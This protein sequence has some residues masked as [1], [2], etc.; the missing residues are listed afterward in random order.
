[1][2]NDDVIENVGEKETREEVA[3]NQEQVKTYSEEEVEAIKEQMKADNQK[4]WN[5]RWGM[6]KGKMEKEYEKQGQIIN[7]LNEKMQTNNID[8]LT[9]KVFDFYQTD[10]PA[11]KTNSKDDEVLGRND[12]KEVLEFDDEFIEEEANRLARLN[13]TAREEAEFLELR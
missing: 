10:K 5:R 7:L 13:R 1:M 8:D 3:E 12:A 6:E 11:P 4:A 9:E 2:D